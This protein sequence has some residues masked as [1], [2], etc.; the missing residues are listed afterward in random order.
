MNDANC[1]IY[2]KVEIWCKNA[3]AENRPF[4]FEAELFQQT[5]TRKSAEFGFPF[6]VI[7]VAR[8]GLI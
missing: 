8:H 4:L 3:V 6:E 1:G 7:V 2:D 5:L